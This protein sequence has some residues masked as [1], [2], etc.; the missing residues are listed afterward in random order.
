MLN[1]S[2]KILISDR[3]FNA[4]QELQPEV[5]NIQW[6]F[7]RIGGCEQ[8]SFE[9]P[10]RFC[11]DLTLGGDFNIKIYWR[12][13]STKA[14][15]LRFQ[16]RMPH[17]NY[18]VRGDAETIRIQGTGYQSQLS[19]IYIARTYSAQTVE[20]I[21]TDIL[22]TDI[23]PNTDI[24]YDGGDIEATGVTLDEMKFNTDALK[25]IQTLSETVGSREWGVDQDRKFYF[26][27]RSSSVGY[28]YPLS[29]KVT[30]FAD[31]I[32]VEDIANRII[33]VG[34]DID[35]VPFT[36]TFNYAI[37]QLKW[38]RRDRVV[39]NASIVTSAVAQRFADA[40][41][42]EYGEAVHMGKMDLLDD[43][44]FEATLPIPLLQPLPRQITYG[45]RP[46]GTFL[47]NGRINYQINKITYRIN[48][49]GVMTA[50]LSLGTLRPQIS[51][52]ISQL[53][54]QIDQLRQKGT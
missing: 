8:F 45:E 31:D 20:D 10:K 19:Q 3:A 52:D 54:Y 9:I 43:R 11:T 53:A 47:Y 26:K 7:G 13:P 2:H 32:N 6:G 44:M 30:S 49:E 27:A 17:K 22:D 46:Y 24:T 21:I 28:R 29:G 23:V 25:V 5:S 18:D 40:I 34:G 12:N 15:D 48:N 36:Q 39:Q 42:A 35:G 1:Q 4:L 14:Y 37:S 50:S 41:Y 51:E 33:I 16:G 38:G